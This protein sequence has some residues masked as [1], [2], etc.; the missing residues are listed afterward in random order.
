MHVAT[1]AGL[2]AVPTLQRYVFCRT[3]GVT[4]MI[5]YI[6]NTRKRLKK[7]TMKTFNILFIIC[8]LLV[9]SCSNDKLQRNSIFNKQVMDVATEVAGIGLFEKLHYKFVGDPDATPNNFIELSLYNSHL[10]DATQMQHIAQKSAKQFVQK[11]ADGKSY[12]SITVKIIRT[13]ARDFSKILH[14][15]NYTFNINDL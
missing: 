1:I 2:Y 7:T 10:A 4:I 8:S 14:E 9:I 5:F 3:H 11:M 6:F 15:Q 12:H 13:P